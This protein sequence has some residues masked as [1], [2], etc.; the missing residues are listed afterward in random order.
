MR[1]QC[2]NCSPMTSNWYPLS[3]HSN[4]TEPNGQ[5]SGVWS[6]FETCVSRQVGDANPVRFPSTPSPLEHQCAATWTIELSSSRMT[7]SCQWESTVVSLDC[8]SYATCLPSYLSDAT[9]LPIWCH[10]TVNW[11]CINFQPDATWLPIWCHLNANWMP[12]HCKSVATCLSMRYH[13]NVN[14]MP[15]ECQWDA[16]WMSIRC[17]LTANW[18]TLS[19]HSHAI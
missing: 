2:L 9:L 18:L 12:C 10:F 13:L 14:Q 19:C 6:D 16:N 11:M 7:I 1:S 8:Q 15:L 5:A 17:H 3:C 4:L